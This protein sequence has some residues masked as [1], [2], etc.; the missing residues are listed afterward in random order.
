MN[1]PLEPATH[2]NRTVQRASG[3]T[4]A[5]RYLSR[6]CER[7]F[8]SLWSYP[9]VYRNQG[10]PGLAGHG[11]EVADLLV[12]FGDHIIIFSDKDCAF[13]AS[14]DLALDWSRWYRN[15]ILEGTK[16][17]WGAERWIRSHP[18][19]LFLDRACRRPFP[20]PL[21]DPTRARFHRV[22]VAHGASARCK[23]ELGGSGSLMFASDADADSPFTAGLIDPTKGF[24]HVLDDTSLGIVLTVLDTVSDFI[25][26]LTAK[27]HLIASGKH[28]FAAGEEELLG[29]YLQHT[30]ARDQHEI[31]TRGYDA[32]ALSEGIWA[33]WA[34]SDRRKAQQE[35]DR[36]SYA[37]DGLIQ[38]FAFFASQGMQYYCTDEGVGHTERILRFMAAENRTHRR[39]LARK[40]IDLV[41]TPGS[42]LRR[43]AFSVPADGSGLMYVFL[44][45]GKPARVAEPEYRETRRLLLEAYCKVAK[46]RYPA[47]VDVVGIAA[48]LDDDNRSEDALYLDCHDWTAEQEA[49]ARSLQRDLGLFQEYTLTRTTEHEFPIRRKT[50]WESHISHVPRMKGRNRNEPCP[51]GSGRKYK[52]CCGDRQLGKPEDTA[53]VALEHP[54]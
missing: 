45:L 28:I 23:K 27:E 44:A 54:I 25:G 22:V 9:A 20:I 6:L 43:A 49:D 5:E 14:G 30:G 39:A 18:D 12:V 21:P 16:Q 42:G 34:E 52:R 46:L 53:K 2:A 48:D 35:A 11:K 51:C 1:P 10:K 3:V 26:F 36:V 8:L 31:R 7:S 4:P 37:W 38:K 50:G 17:V 47:V 33:S 29:Y 13:P 24:V 41:T 19:R 40:L 15:A 32:I